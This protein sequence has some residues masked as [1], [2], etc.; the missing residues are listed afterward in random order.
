M[1]PI[2]RVHKDL[3]LVNDAAKH[4]ADKLKKHFGKRVLGP[5]FPMISRIRNLFHKTIL[6][7]IERESSVVQVKKIIVEE[8]GKFKVKG[9]YKSV[10]VNMD[11]DPM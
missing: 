2:W 9:E 5:E 7:K 10:R 11:V 3:D 1:Q 8:L 6:I 4:I